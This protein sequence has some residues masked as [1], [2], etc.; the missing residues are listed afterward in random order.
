ME[1]GRKGRLQPGRMV[2]QAWLPTTPQWRPA[3]KAGFTPRPYPILEG[4]AD[5]PQWRPAGKA[6]FNR[7]RRDAGR[8]TSR[9]AAM[10]AGR[11]GRLQR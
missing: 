3:G 8:D 5:L 2:G 7:A 6:G 4:A 9:S 10:E 1:A 11:K